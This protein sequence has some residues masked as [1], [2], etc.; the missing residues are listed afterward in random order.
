MQ[1]YVCFAT[2][3]EFVLASPWV[4][5]SPSNKQYESLWI[6]T[7]QPLYSYV[8]YTPSWQ[9]SKNLGPPLLIASEP[10]LRDRLGDFCFVSGHK[11]VTRSREDAEQQMLK[12]AA[13]SSS[14]RAL[15]LHLFA[16]MGFPYI[17]LLW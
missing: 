12:P 14:L 10:E 15:Q 1:S 3:G 2:R 4:S 16:R 9:V 11:A 13:F 8:G 7:L 17:F 5:R 6:R